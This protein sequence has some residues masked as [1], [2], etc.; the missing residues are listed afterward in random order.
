MANHSSK[1]TWTAV[2]A[3]AK[4][5]RAGYQVAKT[6]GYVGTSLDY[7]MSVLP[8]ETRVLDLDEHGRC[9]YEGPLKDAP[10]VA[11]IL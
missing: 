4:S 11:S 7:A 2:C 3:M 8:E 10:A 6:H 1:H 5:I 9:T